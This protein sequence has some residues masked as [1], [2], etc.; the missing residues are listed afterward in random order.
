MKKIVT[1][2]MCLISGAASMAGCTNQDEAFTHKSYTAEVEKIKEVCINVRDRQIE[3]LLS[4][5]DKNLPSNKE[6]GA[7]SLTASINT[8]DIRIEFIGE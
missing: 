5:D 1:C 3:V 4:A 6:G 7:K 8:G 2:L